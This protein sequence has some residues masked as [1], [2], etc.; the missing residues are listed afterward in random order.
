MKRWWS[1][2]GR[3]LGT[4]GLGLG[5]LVTFLLSPAVLLAQE[6]DAAAV[7]IAV[8]LEGGEDLTLESLREGL[9]LMV[10]GDG[11]EPEER[12][13]DDGEGLLLFVFAL[14][15]GQPRGLWR[16]RRIASLGVG[17][18]AWDPEDLPEE[19]SDLLADAR[20]VQN[21]GPYVP[22]ASLMASE[23]SEENVNVLRE[24]LAEASGETPDSFVAFIVLPMEPSALE[25]T[26]VRPLFGILR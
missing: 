22:A 13:Y 1:P 18:N 15:D 21:G 17:R 12:L 20:L 25:S 11:L 9:I 23:P 4:A 7:R 26:A 3:D 16:S 5:V 2:V 8:E 14:R 24:A 6:D 19:L 10:E